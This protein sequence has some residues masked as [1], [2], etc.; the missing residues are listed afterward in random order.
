MH[1]VRKRRLIILLAWFIFLSIVV[2]LVLYALR[3]NIS[4]FYTP[5]ELAGA[6]IP[7]DQLIRVGGMVVKG[8]LRHINKNHEV[9]FTIT[10]FAKSVVVR[11]QGLLPDLFREGQGVVIN[12]HYA[13][14]SIKA[15]EV[16]AKHD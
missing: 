5:K 2:S 13:N 16:L 8:S 12:G 11:Y 6:S 10:D 4:L 1:H 3:Q 15:V 9:E 14:N 7:K